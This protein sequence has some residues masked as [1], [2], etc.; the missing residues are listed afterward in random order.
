MENEHILETEHIRKK[1]GD[2]Q[3]LKDINLKVKKEKLSASS[4]L[5]AQ[6]IGA[7]VL[8]QLQ[9]QKKQNQVN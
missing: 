1:F 6:E 3:V 2:L 4:A 8:A 9:F 7:V 5:R